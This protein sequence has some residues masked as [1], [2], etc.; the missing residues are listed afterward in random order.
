MIASSL[1]NN[2]GEEIV[3]IL[4]SKGADV[5]IQSSTGQTALHFCASKDNL[6]IARKLLSLHG[7]AKASAR[8]KD[9][10]GQLP[11]HRAAA[12]AGSGALS[13]VKLLLENKSPLDAS[14]VDG[15]T[16]LHHAISEG[17]GE[18]A[19]ELLKAGGASDKK[20]G[21]GRLAIDTAPDTKVRNGP[22]RLH[23]Q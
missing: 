7:T 20:D 18:V 15:M 22:D 6:D 2:D 5:N 4:L 9:K 10:R 19:M 13:L 23:R 12:A 8:I 16:A 11:L 17:R 21:E 3:N 14:D 1:P